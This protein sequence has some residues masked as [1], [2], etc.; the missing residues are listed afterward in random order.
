MFLRGRYHEKRKQDNWI[1]LNFLSGTTKVIS[2]ILLA[3]YSD[4]EI[5]I[6]KNCSPDVNHLFDEWLWLIF[7]TQ[8]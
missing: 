2:M 6:I 1:I 3:L 7:N 4:R 5:L 8:L